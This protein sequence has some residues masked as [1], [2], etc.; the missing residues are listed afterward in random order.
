[1]KFTIEVQ[2]WLADLVEQR[3]ATEAMG[4]DDIVAMAADRLEVEVTRQWLSK[5]PIVREAHASHRDRHRR[6]KTSVKVEDEK[7][8]IGRIDALKAEVEHL[9]G[10]ISQQDRRVVSYLFNAQ[11]RG[12]TIE[13]L[14]SRVLGIDV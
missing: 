14:E 7:G 9:K 8:G 4:W 11:E 5:M 3:P 1:M 12:V 6:W 10:I 2:R 13:Q